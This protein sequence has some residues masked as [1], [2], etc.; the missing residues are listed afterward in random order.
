MGA[1]GDHP[2]SHSYQWDMIMGGWARR[3]S[4]CLD[5]GARDFGVFATGSYAWNGNIASLMPIAWSK[6]L[7]WDICP[8]RLGWRR[9]DLALGTSSTLWSGPNRPCSAAGGQLWLCS[10]PVLEITSLC[11]PPANSRGAHL[12]PSHT[13]PGKLA[14]W[15]PIPQH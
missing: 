1:G 4:A 3:T 7:P 15:L 5:V 9:L 11:T 10:G 13:P 14:Q 8:L 12:E 2:G 6:G